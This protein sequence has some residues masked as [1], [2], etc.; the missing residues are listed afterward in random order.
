MSW[1]LTSS[2]I[3][4]PSSPSV[5]GNVNYLDEYEEGDWSPSSTI[6]TV[7]GSLGH[8]IKVGKVVTGSFQFTFG[9]TTSGSSQGVDG[10]PFA[11]NSTANLSSGGACVTN[12][13]AV[14]GTL[15]LRHEGTGGVFRIVRGEN[16][17]AHS[18]ELSATAVASSLIEGFIQYRASA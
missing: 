10:E 6:G 13:G 15:T 7:T 5:S 2:G 8:Y 9:S 18:V 3:F 1:S 12:C 17:V 16:Q 4:A 14:Q 11:F